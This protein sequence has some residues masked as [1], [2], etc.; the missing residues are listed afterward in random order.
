[1]V[2]A[3]LPSFPFCGT[4]QSQIGGVLEQKTICE[5]AC[6]GVE[7]IGGVRHPS[8]T[9]FRGLKQGISGAN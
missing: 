5:R 9:A 4:I 7:C 1:M 2:L 6:L 8:S 3:I